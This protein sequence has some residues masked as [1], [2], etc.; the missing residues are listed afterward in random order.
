MGAPY[1]TRIEAY[2]PQQKAI[3]FQG[4]WNADSQQI[5]SN[6]RYSLEDLPRFLDEPGE[7]WFEKRGNGG[8]L[9]VRLPGDIDP[10]SVVIEAARH[11][12]LIDA[13][14]ADHLRISGLTFRFNNIFWELTYQGWQHPDAHCAAIR[15]LGAGTGIIIDHCRF[16]HVTQ[17]LRLEAGEQGRLDEI[18]VLD[19]NVAYTDHGGIEIRKHGPR[20]LGD[21]LV[22]RNR[23]AEI[24]FR[25]LRVNGHMAL[26]VAFPETAEIA[27]NIVERCGGAGLFLFGGKGDGSSEDVPFSRM[28]VHHNK[29]VDPLLIA[30]DWGGIE[31]W[32]GGPFY[33][34]NNVSGNPGGLMH[35]TFNNKKDGTPRFGHAYYLDGAFKNYH[36]NNIAW[37]KNNELGSK[38]ANCAAFQEII[39]YQNTFFNNTVYKFVAASR[40]QAPQAGRDKFLGNIFEDVSQLVFRHSDK[41]GQDPNARD[42]GEQVAQFAYETDAYG[43]NVF[44]DITGKFG[45]FE[46]EG[47]DYPDLASFAAALAR[48]NALDS[49]VGI[50]TSNALLRN[51]AAH[52]FRLHP[53]SAAIDYGVKVFVPWSLYAVV[54]EWN[55]TRNNADPSNVIDEHWYMTSYYTGRD[56]YYTRPTYPLTAIRVS[57]DD[58]VDGPLEDWTRGALKL[59]GKGQYLVL[60]QAELAKP[61]V[62]EA[63]G[64]RDDRRRSGGDA[65]P[66]IEGAALK[67]PQVHLTSFLLEA[68][69]K[70][71]P[72]QSRGTIIAKMGSTA[73]YALELN[74]KGG[75]TLTIRSGEPVSTLV[76]TTVLNDGGWHHVIAEVDRPGKRLTMYVDGKQTSTIESRLPLGSSLAN[77]ADLIAGKDLACTFEFLRI[78]LGTLVDARTTID[79]LYT[80]Q[81]N[82]PQFR[83][84]CSRVPLGRRDAG[85]LECV[86]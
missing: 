32:Q 56:N 77:E 30:N 49:G 81:F 7:F 61:F 12:N 83:D 26:T 6:N 67:N 14:R 70:T 16:E 34:Y 36:F 9:Y 21:V 74:E 64:R 5:H 51:A 82:G 19:N 57:A 27:G 24:G 52:D 66:P 60:S 86:D 72:W 55:F 33:V 35:W 69:L 10:S 39:S 78:A 44:R 80:W 4:P 46:A 48:H 25:P 13:T 47:G 23:L 85:A 63:R 50:M 84:F 2:D 15:L 31:T 1:A 20:S 40:R 41:E 65:A 58:Y 59:D 73:G 38:Y 29:V 18:A 53:A 68:Y 8:R 75:A 71:K 79:E 62:P 43:R 42:A 54:G 11:N 28:L 3:V 17:A 45:V 22:L 76:D 37:G